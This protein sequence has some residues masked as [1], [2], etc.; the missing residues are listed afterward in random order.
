MLKT[1]PGTGKRCEQEDES[2][3]EGSRA[4]GRELL[5]DTGLTLLFLHDGTLLKHVF[6]EGS[7]AH[8]YKTFDN[9]R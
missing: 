3:R 6:Y 8:L 9:F 7:K 4:L 5:N 2:L 1:S